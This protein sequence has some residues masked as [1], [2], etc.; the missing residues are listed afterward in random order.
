MRFTPASSRVVGRVAQA[1][2]IGTVLALL[3][4]AP[5]SASAA[6]ITAPSGAGATSPAT[7]PAT[8]QPRPALVEDRHPF[9]IGA[10]SA[11]TPYIA[12]GV[13]T[14]LGAESVTIFGQL[15]NS[16]AAW[17]DYPLVHVGLFDATDHLLDTAE[18]ATG[19]IV[20]P[21]NV[22]PYRIDWAIPLGFDH[23]APIDGTFNRNIYAYPTGGVSLARGVAFTDGAGRHEVG[24]A[25]NGSSVDIDDVTV[26]A[27]LL[28]AQGTVL[29]AAYSS[30]VPAMGPGQQAAYEVIIP[31][32]YAGAVRAVIALR[33]TSTSGDVYDWANVLGDL[34]GSSV[35]TDILWLADARITAGCATNAYCP[36]AS[37]T[38]GEMASFLAR[39]LN[40][41]P[42]ATDY[43]TDDNGTT[44]ENN[45]NRVAKAHITS[46]CG[47]LIYCPNAPVSRGQMAS[48]LARALGLTAGATTDYFTDDNGTTHEQ[49]INRLR[50]A[51]IT[52]GCTAT[53]YCP[54][55][56]V[57]RGQMAAFLH[58]AFGP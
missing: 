19:E 35:R 51:G 54:A 34:Y 32:H 30:F 23:A 49:N 37:V 15:V 2:R 47:E 12:A 39:A 58:R 36:A 48:F 17:L 18:Y 44:H 52:M 1:M 14:W 10:G 3:A 20:A 31:D 57:T 40:L 8:S 46:G 24:V 45:I 55:A 26:S 27:T 6:T 7:S 21:G 38:R 29:V 53:T 11:G 56:N 28:D 41:P 22:M 4:L 42:S 50:F 13:S 33:A 5:V 43:F 16:S 25:T 9:G